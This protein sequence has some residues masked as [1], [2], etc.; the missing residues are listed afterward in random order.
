MVRMGKIGGSEEME[1]MEEMR[2]W[3]KSEQRRFL[4]LPADG[5]VCYSRC[6]N[7]K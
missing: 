2:K 3:R 5:M 6:D 1:E 7:A 4:D